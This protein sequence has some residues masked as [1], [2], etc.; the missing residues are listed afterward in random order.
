M[1][2]SLRADGLRGVEFDGAIMALWNLGLDTKDIATRLHERE[3]VVAN[4][5]AEIRDGARA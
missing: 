2:V 1:N 4:R 3:S 5:L